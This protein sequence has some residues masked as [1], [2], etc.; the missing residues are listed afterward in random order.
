MMETQMSIYGI[1]SRE[2]MPECWLLKKDYRNDIHENHIEIARRYFDKHHDE[3]NFEGYMLCWGS[4]SSL[5]SVN[6]LIR[7]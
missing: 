6:Q 3:S 2:G 5:Y 4:R 7:R 1:R